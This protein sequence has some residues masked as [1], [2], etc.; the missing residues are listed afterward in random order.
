MERIARDLTFTRK[1]TLGVAATAALL[2][3][4]VI[5]IAE[6]PAISA[7]TSTVSA[8]KFETAS[9]KP[10]GAFR[11]N[12]APY[13]FPGKVFS[14]CTTVQRFIGQAY[15]NFANGHVHRLSSAAVTGGPAWVD[16]DLYE[17]DM[18]TEEPQR[19]AVMNGPMLQAL[20]EDRFKLKIHRETREVPVYAMTVAR[21]GPE[22]QPFR[23]NCVP[24]DFDNPPRE[25]LHPELKRPLQPAESH[26]PICGTAHA[27]SNGPEMT[28]W[29]MTDLRFFFLVTLDRPVID[30]TG[31]TGRF[32][33]HLELPSEDLEYFRGAH[34]VPSRGDPASS[35]TSPSFVSAIKTAVKKLGLNLEPTSGPGEFLV[36]DHIE[37]PSGD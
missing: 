25:P 26:A 1:L 29:T 34:G 12:T 2:M 10:C 14:G 31:L 33:F 32:N 21:G 36:I 6:G 18:T 30:E 24:W 9:I 23:G 37:R 19:L 28:A 17:I 27:T 3:P 35:A 20:L 8:P 15:G 7:L 5:G 16:S 11:R 22:L 13:L 4:I